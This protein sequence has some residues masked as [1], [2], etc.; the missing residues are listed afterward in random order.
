M[1][2]ILY[3]DNH[4]IIVN[5][6]CGDIVQGD[7]TGDKTLAEDV[8]DYIK[9]KYSKT[10]NVYLGITHRLDRPTSGIVVFARTS[11]A[12]TRLNKM[13]SEHDIKKSYLAVV[14]NMPP[15]TEGK[16]TH[17]L[18][19]NRK[20]NKSYASNTEKKDS[21][22]AE[23]LYKLLAESDKY[24]LLEIDLLTGRHH[25]I[26]AQ[27]AAVNCRIKGDLKYG[28]PRSNNNAGIHLHAHKI[29]LIHP[30]SKIKINITA[31]PPDDNLWNYFRNY[32]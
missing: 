14:D 13:F 32:L 28:F 21:K 29:E 15:K 11:K 30:V 16:L 25:Q 20:Q 9:K 5:K 23:L 17:F 24:F 31:P 12:L 4:I 26:R 19:R 22:K 7:K 1:P 27:L 18:V 2:K 10:G 3:E 8:K 6:A